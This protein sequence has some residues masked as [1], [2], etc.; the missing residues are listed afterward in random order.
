MLIIMCIHT[1]IFTNTLSG[2]MIK[3]LL[4]D[5]SISVIHVTTNVTVN[6]S[7]INSYEVFKM[8]ALE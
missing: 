1:C 8:I 5:V 6:T 7:S 4:H 3:S 2:C